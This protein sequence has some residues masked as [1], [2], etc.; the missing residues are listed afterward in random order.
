MRPRWGVRFAWIA[1]VAVLSNSLLPSPFAVG[2]GR[3]ATASSA[4]RLGFCGAISARG[5]PVKTKPALIIHHCAL[6]AAA[7]YVLS[8]SRQASLVLPAVASEAPLLPRATA[9][10]AF[11]GHSRAQPR[12]PPVLA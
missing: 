1:I 12:A 10:N 11:P 9:P 4:V 2:I 5:T 6:C 3:L 8:P 7:Q